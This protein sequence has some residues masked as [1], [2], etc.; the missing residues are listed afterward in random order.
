M[1]STPE[2]NSPSTIA[3]AKA[4]KSMKRFVKVMSS[5]GLILV[6]PLG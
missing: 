1:N 3:T 4:M 2:K 5:Y 6:P